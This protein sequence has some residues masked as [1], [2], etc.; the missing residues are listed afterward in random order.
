MPPPEV[1]ACVLSFV[2]FGTWAPAS[3]VC[4]LWYELSARAFDPLADEEASVVFLEGASEAAIATQ[5]ERKRRHAVATY[6]AI[7][8]AISRGNEAAAIY[9]SERRSTT[10]SED[11]KLCSAAV[12]KCMWRVASLLE[13][14][15]DY[16]IAR[17]FIGSEGK[18]RGNLMGMRVNLTTRTVTGFSP[19]RTPHEER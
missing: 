11:A 2:P 7:S 16:G 3:R 8:I 19:T 18:S 13:P 17:G 5:L 4:W 14:K 9:L 1:W 10:G 15:R 6:A 12:E